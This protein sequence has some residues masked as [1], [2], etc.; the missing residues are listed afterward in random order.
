MK[1][2][3]FESQTT[4]NLTDTFLDFL[5]NQWSKWSD[6]CALAILL[7]VAWAVAYCLFGGVVGFD[8]QLFSLAVSSS[9]FCNDP[10]M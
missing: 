2:T 3:I 4:K 9:N 8:S 10:G 7:V 5:K 6:T 1:S